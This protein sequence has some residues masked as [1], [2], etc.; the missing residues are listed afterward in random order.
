MPILPVRNSEPVTS[1]AGARRGCGD[2]PCNPGRRRRLRIPACVNRRIRLPKKS[3]GHVHRRGTAE[4][5]LGKPFSSSSKAQVTS[6]ARRRATHSPPLADASVARYIT[7]TRGI[8]GRLQPPTAKE[9]SPLAAIFPALGNIAG[10]F[11]GMTAEPWSCIVRWDRGFVRLTGSGRAA[12]R[13][14]SVLVILEGGGG[15]D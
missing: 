14:V 13:D 7:S 9:P 5:R 3:P 15:H 2:F 6:H 11:I 1:R 10:R 8:C 12:V 4:S